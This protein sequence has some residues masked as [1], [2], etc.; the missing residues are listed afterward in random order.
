M[1]SVTVPFMNYGTKGVAPIAF[2]IWMAAEACAREPKSKPPY[3]PTSVRVYVDEVPAAA[4]RPSNTPTGMR[5]VDGEF[6]PEAEQ[7]CLRWVGAVGAPSEL[8]EANAT[9]KKAL[10]KTQ[11]EKIA[12]GLA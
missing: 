10:D 1:K 6:C 11:A 5:E 7:D 4:E 8:H 2:V 3:T 9:R 12:L